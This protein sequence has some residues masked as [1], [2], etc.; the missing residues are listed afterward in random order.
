MEYSKTAYDDC[1]SW[2]Y[3]R[4]QGVWRRRREHRDAARKR[5]AVKRA[6]SRFSNDIR[7]AL[8]AAYDSATPILVD[9]PSTRESRHAADMFT[10]QGWDTAQTSRSEVFLSNKQGCRSI[11]TWRRLK[12]TEVSSCA[13]ATGAETAPHCHV[14][15]AL[16]DQQ[17]HATFLHHQAAEGCNQR[18]CCVASTEAGA[19]CHQRIVA[20]NEPPTSPLF[21]YAYSSGYSVWKRLC[22]LK[23][24]TIGCAYGDDDH[25]GDV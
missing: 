17:H 20:R 8:L 12:E 16:S 9:R 19:V 14:Q 4:V 5:R 2:Q 6:V 1:F 10:R 21:R 7:L 15:A 23:I 22:L 3:R 25:D 13:H 18:L 24:S 11:N